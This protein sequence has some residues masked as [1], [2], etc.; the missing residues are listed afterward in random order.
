MEWQQIKTAPKDGTKF[1]MYTSEGRIE[2]GMWV[3]S[4][5]DG[6]DCMGSDAGWMSDSGMTFPGRSFGNPDYHS[7]PQD[8][9]TH[10]MPLPTCPTTGK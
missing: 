6:T 5:S 3:C 2:G 1:L 10:W 9:P 7:E 4:E 8:P